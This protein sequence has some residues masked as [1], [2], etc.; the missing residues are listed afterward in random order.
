MDPF[1]QSSPSLVRSKHCCPV[2]SGCTYIH[3]YIHVA[4]VFFIKMLLR[5]ALAVWALQQAAVGGN[6]TLQLGLDIQQNLVFLVLPLQGTSDLRQLSL[7]VIDQTLH[8]GQQGCVAGLRLCQQ[9]LLG[10]SLPGRRKAGFRMMTPL[11]PGLC[12]LYHS[13]QWFLCDRC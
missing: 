9:A 8:L 12:D 11:S 1:I 2:A 7:E 3:T 4:S 13:Q 5:Y 10:V 6:L